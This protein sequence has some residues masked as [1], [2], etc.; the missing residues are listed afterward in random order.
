MDINLNT[1]DL[2]ED[3]L[4]R[5]VRLIME[6]HGVLAGEANRI[7]ESYKLTLICSHKICETKALQAALLTAVNCGKRSFLGGVEVVMPDNIP[8]LI[9]WPEKKTLNE[10]VEELNGKIVKKSDDTS[11]TLL[12]G[13]DA[14]QESS[15]HVICNGWV[16][17]VSDLAIPNL[18]SISPDFA[19]G[20]I[21][22]GALGVAGAFYR[23]TRIR[24]IFGSE[25][26]GISLWKPDINWLLPEATGC[27]LQFLPQKFWVLGLGHLGQSY[28]WSIGLLSTNNM[29]KSMEVLLQDFD[30]I[31][32]ANFS[33][34][35][36]SEEIH[37]N[38]KKTRI[39]AQWLEKRQIITTILEQ[40]FNAKTFIDEND[41]R[42]AL[43]G[44]DKAEPR[45]L[46]E[47]VGFDFIVEAGIGESMDNFD[48]F[49]VHT[50]PNGKTKAREIWVEDVYPEVDPKLREAFLKEIGETGIC[51]I[52]ASTLAGKAIATSFVGAVA[53]AF[54][55]G[56]ILKGLHNEAFS[57]TLN[58]QLRSLSDVHLN[59]STFRTSIIAQS[60]FISF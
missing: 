28:L 3:T 52:R 49:I 36:L 59:P 13:E 55:I 1:H 23:V 20:G 24:R 34:G 8:L 57:E 7:L 38:K 50:F 6:K 12:F 22:A 26:V 27:P 11:F 17:G 30:V 47:D 2:S 9:N 4:H 21:V 43:C 29:K 46:L 48:D 54:A 42:I 18:P 40:R 19:L 41:P 15:L 37:I 5:L 39:C 35:L 60:G 56:E 51:G 31:K 25:P 32:K 58:V 10:A 53:G 44:F 45:R 14:D 33:T 16:G